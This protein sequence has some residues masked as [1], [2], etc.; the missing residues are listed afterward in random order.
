[1]I[2]SSTVSR[3]TI[4]GF[5]CPISNVEFLQT[6]DTAATRDAA[7]RAQQHHTANI[8]HEQD[9]GTPRDRSLQDRQRLYQAGQ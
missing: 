6:D 2:P 8:M 9:N 1:M 3:G 7:Y 4:R 5:R